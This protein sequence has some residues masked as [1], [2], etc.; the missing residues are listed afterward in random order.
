MKISDEEVKKLMGNHPTSTFADGSCHMIPS[1]GNMGVVETDEGLVIFDVPQKRLAPRAFKRLREI[2]NKP[3]KYLIISH[4]HFDHAYGFEP[5]VEEIKD[6]EL[7]M[8]EIIIHE[9][10]VERFKRYNMLDKYHE[11]LN[12]QQFSALTK[13]KGKFF[14]AHEEIEPT[15]I[16]HVAFFKSTRMI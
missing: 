16:I 9:N 4:G 14:P 6:K 11:W 5:I 13:G 2:T 10:C 7:D 12:Q 8:P 15:M 1:F 3:V